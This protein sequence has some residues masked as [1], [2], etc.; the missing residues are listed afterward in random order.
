MSKNSTYEARDRYIDHLEKKMLD[1]SSELASLKELPEYKTIYAEIKK[2]N[3]LFKKAMATL[4]EKGLVY[5]IQK[6][7]NKLRER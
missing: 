5:T 2:E 6:T 1:L 7:I 4:R 3:T